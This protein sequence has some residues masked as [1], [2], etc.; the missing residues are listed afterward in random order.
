VVSIECCSSLLYFMHTTIS[1]S[2]V[3]ASFPDGKAKHMNS[4][5][6]GNRSWLAPFRAGA[7]RGRP[8]GIG[9]P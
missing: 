3:A 4:P 5:E 9:L 8:T 2:F 1:A 7:A 6:C